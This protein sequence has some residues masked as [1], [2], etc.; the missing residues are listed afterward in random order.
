MRKCYGRCL[1]KDTYLKIAEHFERRKR[2]KINLV[3]SSE[4]NFKFKLHASMKQRKRSEMG[5]RIA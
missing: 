1:P 2:K 4:S 3:G 5:Q